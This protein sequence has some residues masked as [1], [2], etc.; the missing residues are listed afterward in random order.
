M[1][2]G[3]VL[4]ILAVA[5]LFIAIIVFASQSAVHHKS[6]SHS[7]PHKTLIPVSSHVHPHV[8]Y[9]KHPSQSSHYGHH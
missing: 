6:A 2:K 8:Y 3:H 7:V 4:T 1:N 9:N 5:A